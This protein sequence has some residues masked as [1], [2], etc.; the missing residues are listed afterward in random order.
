MGGSFGGY[1]L[2]EVRVS[3]AVQSDGTCEFGEPTGRCIGES[4]SEIGCIGGFTCT[5]DGPTVKGGWSEDGN[6]TQLVSGNVCSP[7]DGATLCAGPG[8]EERPECACLCDSGWP[9]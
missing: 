8:S 1:C 2:W 5:P 4:V 7:F 6:E 3:A 9:G